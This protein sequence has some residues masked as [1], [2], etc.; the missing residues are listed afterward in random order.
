MRVAKRKAAAAA[1]KKAKTDENALLWQPVFH[2]IASSIA[3]KT[4]AQSRRQFLFKLI[5]SRDF[6]FLI[7]LSEKKKRKKIVLSLLCSALLMRERLQHR[8]KKKRSVETKKKVYAFVQ[9]RA[10]KN[11]YP[12]SDKMVHL[13]ISIFCVAALLPLHSSLFI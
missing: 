12:F 3:H 6:F 5:F 2:A 11:L 7:T 9:G 4:L 1:R 10:E 13:I 8:Q